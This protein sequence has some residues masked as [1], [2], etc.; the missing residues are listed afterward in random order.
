MKVALLLNTNALGGA[1]RSVIEQLGLVRDKLSLNIYIPKLSKSSDT[2]VNFIGSKLNSNV[3]F[4]RMPKAF[5]NVGQHGKWLSLLRGAFSLLLAPFYFVDL[6]KLKEK[7]V[8]Y[9]NGNKIAI[10]TLFWA[11][12]ANYKGKI[13]WHFRDYPSQN[14]AF[15]AF[16]K[17][18][19]KKFNSRLTFVAN[20][21]SVA[22]EL[23]VIGPKYV[24]VI[25]NTVG[26]MPELSLAKNITNIGV[27]SMMASWKGIHQV[28]L[29]THLYEKEL[30]ALGIENL[31]IFSSEIYQTAGDHQT[32]N[33]ELKKLLKKFPTSLVKIEFDKSPIQIFNQIDLLIHPSL[34][35][36]PFGRVI[37]EAFRSNVPVISTSL[38]GANELIEQD[39]NGL[40]FF[41]Y[42]YAGLF[43][44]IKKL[45]NNQNIRKEI[46]VNAFKKSFEI[47]SNVKA[48]LENILG[49]A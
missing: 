22:D 36:E 12:L 42:D 46:T 30:I 15:C 11:T 6:V 49:V 48:N 8:L 26:E 13:I 31:T 24:N 45:I 47:E 37:L 4:Y 28:V 16:L 34:Q 27:V 29:M 32:Y 25:Y 5:Y 1:E 38:G 39:K 33:N 23:K 19:N 43:L 20:S 9:C 7:D 40:T 17:Y 14:F 18:M 21:Q 10:W 3:H 41:K 2:I 35:K 44:L